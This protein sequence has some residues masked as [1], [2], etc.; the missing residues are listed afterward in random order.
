MGE[1]KGGGR[2][3]RRSL[4]AGENNWL[5]L[6]LRN[7]FLV[8]KGHGKGKPPPRHMMPR[9]GEGERTG[10]LEGVGQIDTA[11]EVSVNGLIR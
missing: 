7:P 8:C 11:V 6:P 2:R 1:G 10:K 3:C 4:Q 5:Q 9:R